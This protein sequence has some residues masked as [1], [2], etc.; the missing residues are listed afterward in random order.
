VLPKEGSIL[1]RPGNADDLAS[2]L[3]DLLR[4]PE[5]RIQMGRFNREYAIQHFA[6][7][8]VV[9]ELER[10]YQDTLSRA[11]HST[12][13]GRVASFASRTSTSTSDSVIPPK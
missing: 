6:W 3:I 5:R 11:Q 2:A 4:S 12:E 7:P 9:D 1:V 8:A 10:I 13:T